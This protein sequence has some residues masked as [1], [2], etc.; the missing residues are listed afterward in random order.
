VRELA[1]W[2]TIEGLGDP[3]K[4]NIKGIVHDK[5]KELATL[6]LLLPLELVGLE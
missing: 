4:I 5:T 6:L 2:C 3:I 1:C